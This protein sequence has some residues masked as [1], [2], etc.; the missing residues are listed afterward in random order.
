MQLPLF[1]DKPCP[2]PPVCAIKVIMACRC[3]ASWRGVGC[4]AYRWTKLS[5]VEAGPETRGVDKVLRCCVSDEGHHQYYMSI[6]PL[7][8]SLNLF[9]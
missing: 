5:D 8:R 7:Y 1:Q 3:C 2:D 4:T 6:Y 9:F